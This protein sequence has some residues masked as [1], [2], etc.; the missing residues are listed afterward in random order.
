M[1]RHSLDDGRIERNPCRIKGAGDHRTAER[2]TATVRQV[3]ALAEQM[4]ARIRTLVLAA[5]FTGLRW[6][7]LIGLRRGTQGP[8]EGAHRPR[9]ASAGR[10]ETTPTVRRASAR[11]ANRT[12]QVGA[13]FHDR[14]WAPFVLVRPCERATGIEPA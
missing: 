8:H 11:P 3:H 13:H 7:E 2:P 5:V 14:R 9:P 1:R 4:P 6:G 10:E 12:T